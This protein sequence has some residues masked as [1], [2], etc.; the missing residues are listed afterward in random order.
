MQGFTLKSRPDH[1]NANLRAR[2]EQCETATIGH[3]QHGCFVSP[4]IQ[5][6][7]PS[8]HIVGTAVTIKIVGSDSALLHHIVSDL[9]EGD[10]LCIDRGG[11]LEH[12]C[13]GGGVANAVKARNIAG[14]VI[15]GPC[16]D[17]GEIKR[18]GIPVWCRGRTALTTRLCGY[19]GEYNTIVSIGGLT[20]KPGDAVIADE[21]GVVVLD[22]SEIQSTADRAIGMQEL[23]V[24]FLKKIQGGARL[25][26][27]SGATKMVLEAIADET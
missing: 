3:F 20:V 7:D 18:L 11:D 4:E 25:G 19:G 5:A 23:E 12:A 10:I 8:H 15:D 2:L 21:S 16:T 13:F 26:D 14:V 22:P 24:E 17:V 27:L 9:L 6:I 1:I